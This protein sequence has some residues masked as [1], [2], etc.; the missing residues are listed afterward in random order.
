MAPGAL[1]WAS[2]WVVMS[3]G[4]WKDG[5]VRG[6]T[7]GLWLSSEWIKVVFSE[8]GLGLPGRVWR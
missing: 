2:R 4:T 3:L 6:D 5:H 1:V 7:D 8:A